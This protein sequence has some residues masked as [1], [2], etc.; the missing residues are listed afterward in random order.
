MSRVGRAITPLL[1]FQAGALVL[2]TGVAIAWTVQGVREWRSKIEVPQQTIRQVEARVH[3][4]RIAPYDFLGTQ[5]QGARDR[6]QRASAEAHASLSVLVNLIPELTVEVANAQSALRMLDS[7]AAGIWDGAP[8]LEG[9]TP[10]TELLAEA[11][12]ELS[13]AMGVLSNEVTHSAT[14]QPTISWIGLGSMWGGALGIYLLTGLTAR[15]RF[16]VAR[17]EEQT[18][19]DEALGSVTSALT[20]AREGDR[21]P[22]IKD[23]PI[24][25]PF[26]QAVDELA[27][28]MVNLHQSNKR[29]RRQFTFRHE[30]VDALD[31][32]E[33]EDEVV[34]TA[35]RAAR[36]AFPEKRFQ[37]LVAGEADTP[38]TPVDE[39]APV[40]CSLQKTESCPA[41]RKACTLHHGPD[42]GLARCPRIKNEATVLTCSPVSVNGKSVGVV[43]LVGDALSDGQEELL[44]ALSGALGGR[45]GVVRDLAERDLAAGTDPLT[46]LANRRS[47]DEHLKRLD[48]SDVPYA[49]ITA[50]LDHFKSINDTHGHDV[51]DKC[52]QLFANILHEVS[53]D[54]DTAARPGGEEFA[55]I[56]SGAG[57]DAGMAVASRIRAMLAQ[58]TRRQGPHFT[59]SLGIAARPQHGDRAEEVL[60]SADVALYDAKDQGRD[61]CV[62]AVPMSLEIVG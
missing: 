24:T 25:R 49:V 31:L 27:D 14:T 17:R 23:H 29:I 48:A 52:L 62:A 22:S 8:A 42:M 4:A 39:A 35:V 20:A 54:T 45:M 30:L 16:L 28:A 7:A 15:K 21:L 40:A 41:I 37:L 5:D 55:L 44:E 26:A 9:A 53:R 36:V 3:T 47:M 32:A 33:T 58:A 11:D 18:D 61:Q 38:C 60:R 56:L 43:Q 6:G 57:V 2:F 46:G 19:L 59:A 10:S 34:R 1:G 50:D 51:G 12:L 13:A